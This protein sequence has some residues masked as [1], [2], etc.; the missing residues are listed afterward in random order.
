MVRLNLC[1]KDVVC[2]KNYDKTFVIANIL[3]KNL[4]VVLDFVTFASL[5][6]IFCKGFL[7]FK[8]TKSLFA[9]TDFIA[10]LIAIQEILSHLNLLNRLNAFIFSIVSAT[11]ILQSDSVKKWLIYNIYY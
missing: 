6:Y 7:K 5:C 2:K 8:K 9:F 10:S 1:Y 4:V 11:I 3:R